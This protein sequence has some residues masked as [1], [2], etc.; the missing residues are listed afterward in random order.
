MDTPTYYI[1]GLGRTGF[2][3]A[4]FL[5]EEGR[6]FVAWDDTPG[7]R[8]QF[9]KAMPDAL[10]AD[11]RDHVW[12]LGDVL[13]L[14]PGIA[15]THPI[16]VAAHAAYVPIVVD[17]ELFVA[18]HPGAI[19]LGITGTNGKSTTTALTHH[20]LQEA[21]YDVGLG[22]NIGTSILDCAA[23]PVYVVEL[24]SYQLERMQTKGLAGALLLNMTPDHL[25]RHGTMEGYQRAKGRIF[26]LLKEGGVGVVSVDDAYCRALYDPLT[27]VPFSLEGRALVQTPYLRGRHNHQNIL[28]AY[29]LCKHV[30]GIDDA[31]FERGL[32]SF[33][34]LGHRQEHVVTVR[35]LTFINDSKATNLESAVCALEAYDNLYWLVGG[36][37]KTPTIPLEMVRPYASKIRH[38]YAYGQDR[39]I[40]AR[41]LSPLFPV[42]ITE[43][44]LEA[45]Q[46]A[47]RDAGESGVILLSPACASWDQFRDYEDRGNQFKSYVTQLTGVSHG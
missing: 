38:I 17:I 14:S 32:M 10:V 36:Q 28:G 30:F 29:T 47:V 46:A 39:A 7:A 12:G 4:R 44:L 9:Q 42:S 34:G 1:V 6:S 23:R 24:S 45:T 20:I 41:D 18:S 26:G 40:F 21:G 35:G 2:A 15:E 19:I 8:E 31:V 22:G 13:V 16:A 25:E 33:K 37:G 11:P 5:K 3:T 27:M 43:T